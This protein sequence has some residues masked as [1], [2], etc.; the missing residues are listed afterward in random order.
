MSFLK[1]HTSYS[2]QYRSAVVKYLMLSLSRTVTGLC[3]EGKYI[4]YAVGVYDK[5]VCLCAC[6]CVRVCVCV[7]VRACVHAC[8]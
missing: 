8:L 7:Y 4:M 2:Y 6:V 1:A 3:Q 5:S